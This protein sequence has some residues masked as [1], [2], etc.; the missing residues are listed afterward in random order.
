MADQPSGQPAQRSRERSAEPSTELSTD[1]WEVPP[2]EWND[3]ARPF[4]DRASMI[5]LIERRVRESPDAPA[6]RLGEGEVRTYGEL[7]A[8]SGLLA[9]F[10]A[11]H[12]VGRGAFVG[13]L[14]ENSW[15]SVLAVVGVL[16]TGAAYVP[17][18][19][20][21]PASRI[22][23]PLRQSG[24]AWLVTGHALARRAE[25]AGQLAGSGVRLVCTDLRAAAPDPLDTEAVGLLWDAVAEDEDL[26]RASGFNRNP[27]DSISAA[28]IDTYVAHVRDLV[29]SAAPAAARPRVVEV[30]C[31]AGLIAGALRDRVAGYTGV[32]VSAVAL[33]RAGRE[34]GEGARFVRA[35]AADLGQVLAPASADVVLLASVAQ[36]FPG[37][38]YLRCV[39]RDAVGALAP[40]GAVVLA[41]LAEP[42]EGD[43]S[44]HLRVPAEWFGRLSAQL[45]LPVRAEVHRR[46]GEDWPPVLRDRYD[47]VLRLAPPDTAAPHTPVIST[48]SDV[49]EA[50]ALPLPAGPGADDT[51]YVIFTS[52]STGVPKGV[53]VRHRSAVN[54]IQ[55]V[56]ETYAVGPDDC[57]LW[58]TALT[59]DLS[60]YDLLGVLAAGASLRVVPAAELSDGERL[61]DIMLREPITFWDS[62][63][64]ALGMVMSFADGP[65]GPAG[66]DGTGGP[67]ETG[68]RD[69]TGVPD[70][71]GG[72]GG[73]GGAAADPVPSLRLVFLSG[74]WV[75]LAL[76]GRVRARFPRAHVVALGGATEATIWSNHFD[77]G[78]IDPAW[79]SVPYGK[80]IQNARYYVLDGDRKPCPIGV[81]GDLHI[82]GVVVADGY[83]GDPELT[84]AKFTADTVSGL[85]DES[86]YATGDRARWMADG[87][88]EFRGRRDDQVKVRGYRIELGE[89]LAALRQVPGVVDC[90]VTTLRGDEGPQIVAAVAV[91]GQDPLPRGGFVRRHLA[92]SLPSYMLPE[93]VLVLP[94][95]PV[96]PTGKVDRERLARLAVRPRERRRA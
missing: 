39:L 47:V 6:V 48:W 42:G 81:E 59:F 20:R 45:G 30:G 41:D 28:Q 13:I 54:V 27:G 19:A 49:E 89:V 90:A 65:D 50:R 88:L 7:W 51:A 84:A 1:S 5:D 29:L 77:V 12:G 93:H 95:L 17:L 96:G 66:S 11:G 23:A 80:P 53:S 82:A 67:D 74:D 68:V 61:L 24:I 36:F 57:L 35:A 71:T 63:P 83:V 69:E 18:D 79:T 3:T 4:E 55:W 70:E 87:N 38:E 43:D 91:G 56:N 21:W 73:S 10:L 26:G 62:A 92:Q 76:P 33:E 52:G 22:A 16:R 64:A 86:M 44:G 25:E 94:A 34:A 14:H 9:R 31:G 78:E 58:V 75:P 8:D 2:A 40:G 72:A 85:A 46:D 37:F 32:D 60:V 15:D